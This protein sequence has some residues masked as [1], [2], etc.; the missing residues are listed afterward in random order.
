MDASQT[1][2]L[3]FG[4]FNPLHNGHMGIARY[5][6]DEGLCARV[7]FIVSPQ[8]PWKRNADLLDEDKRLEMVRK[9]IEEDER[10]E[11]SD[12]E[13]SL[14]KPSYTYQTLRVFKE[15]FP[16][17]KFALIIGGDNLQRFREWRNVDEILAQFPILVYPRP[18]MEVGQFPKG[19]ICVA[20]A[21]LCEVSSTEIRKK[22]KTGTDISSDVPERIIPMIEKYYKDKW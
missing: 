19:D 7:C 5:L 15:R 11:V 3:F 17:R 9:A 16:A 14:P 20:N 2:G 22:V 1:V 8:N 12:I 6:L 18:G 10:M 4:S 21:P 13:F